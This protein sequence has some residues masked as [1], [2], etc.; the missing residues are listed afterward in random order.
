MN[1]LFELEDPSLVYDLRHHLAGRQAKFD[2]FWDEA[3]TFIH[4]DIG[5]AVDDRRH[6]TVIHIAKAVSV[7]DLRE[8]V[9]SRCPEGT[10]VPSD[11][12]IRLQFAP[13]SLSSHT[14]LRY[15]GKLEVKRQV[16][17]RQFRKS[18]PDSHY[19]ACLYRYQ[20]EYAITV[21]DHAV[22]VCLDDKH[23]IKVGEPNSPVAAAERG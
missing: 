17:Q 19:A 11:E 10:P 21:H 22:F 3:K 16:Q 9:V 6:S 4:E 18:H 23:K 7:R 12:Q 20:R 15:T 14:A 1:L 8:Q 2:T 13:T 5:V